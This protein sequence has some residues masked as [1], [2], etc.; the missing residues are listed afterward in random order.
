MK[1]K[2]ISEDELVDL[3][4]TNHEINWQ[5]AYK[6]VAGKTKWER[7]FKDEKLVYE[8]FT[9]NGK[10]CG[11]GTSYYPEGNARQEGIWGIKGLLTGRDYY[12]NGQIH[13]EGIFKL[14]QA[15]G[16]NEPEYGSYFDKEGTLRYHG[17]FYVQHGSVGFPRVSVPEKWCWIGNVLGPHILLWDDVRNLLCNSN[18]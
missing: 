10:A 3:F 5:E 17:K 13:F 7:I 2:L 18:E 6:W 4:F 8:G 9:L 1:T 16:P 14:N 11:A 15:Y 12:A